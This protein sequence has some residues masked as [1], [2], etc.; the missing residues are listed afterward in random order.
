[1]KNTVDFIKVC[2]IISP[3][4]GEAVRN[5]YT[6][7]YRGGVAFQSYDSLIAA[8]DMETETLRLGRRYDYSV[9]TLKYLHEWL[10]TYRYNLYKELPQGK[11]FKDTLQKAIAA[12]IIKYDPSMV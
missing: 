3:R 2:P 6:I 9:T 10:K 1:M 4:S 8:Y 11:S 12:G 5:Q 7:K